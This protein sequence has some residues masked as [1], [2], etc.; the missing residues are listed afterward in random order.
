MK[1]KLFYILLIFIL[2]SN[3]RVSADDEG[4]LVPIEG[5][6]VAHVW[7][8][9]NMSQPIPFDIFITNEEGTQTYQQKDCPYT[10]SMETADLPFGDKT[11][12]VL[13]S[14]GYKM[15][16]YYLDINPGINYTFDFYLPP[17]KGQLS[18]SPPTDSVKTQTD[19]ANVV[20]FES[21][22]I[23]GMTYTAI[24][25]TAVYIYDTHSK[26]VEK[27]QSDIAQVVNP[28]IDLDI[29]LTYTLNS[30][31][32]VYI[33]NISSGYGSWE[34]VANSE[35]TYS[36][37]NSKITIDAGQ[38]ND[39][40]TKGRVDYYYTFEEDG[41]SYPSWDLVSNEDYEYY[42]DGPN[43]T[44]FSDA[45][46]ENVT[47]GRVDYTY[48]YEEG[49]VTE[50]PLYV[51]SVIGPEGE[52]SNGGPLEGAKL[53]FKRY[54]EYNDTWVNVSVVYTDANGQV[55]IYL[56]PHVL[57][58]VKVSKDN[59]DLEYSD[60]IPSV[61]VLTHTFRINPV[62]SIEDGRFFEDVVRLFV[63]WTN[64]DEGV[65]GI[66]HDLYDRT[67]WV[68]FSIL[69]MSDNSV[70][71]YSN[72][73]GYY[74]NAT[75]FTTAN[76]TYF[77]KWRFVIRHYFWNETITITGFIAPLPHCVELSVL[78]YYF[79]L[80]FGENPITDANGDP[81]PW[82][83]LIVGFVGFFILISFGSYYAEVGLAGMGLWFSLAYYM[84]PDLNIALLGGGL[85]IFVIAIISALR[86]K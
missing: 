85:F 79:N 37:V 34:S 21:N 53:E 77:Y 29:P 75:G 23:I 84:I 13:Q 82:T 18:G 54:N 48:Q 15:R 38:I 10:V 12:F 11:I 46:N 49:T 4:P 56:V 58:K 72:N 33:Y 24:D 70:L 62:V 30:V 60:Y 7:N 64:T 63:N 69:N 51:I 39:N 2:L 67:L 65:Y 6:V 36:E 17:Y 8:E 41:T 81:I 32:G 3:A 25:I 20:D 31:V 44:I 1:R 42:V 28:A 76:H 27:T 43:T 83:Y 45:L 16:V 52:Y 78:E 19:I 59:Y 57:Y 55:D 22:L 71:Y 50:T 40:I 66:Y 5:S 35:Y 26:E 61:T 9:S 74:F 86:G 80:I 14:E 73:T 47:K 68:N